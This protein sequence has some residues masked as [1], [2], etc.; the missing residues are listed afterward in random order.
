[1]SAQSPGPVIGVI[2]PGLGADDA[3]VA[4][5]EEVGG[6]LAQRGCPVVNGGLDGV[7]AAVSRGAASHGGLVIGILPGEDRSAGHNHL[8]FALPTG[9]GEMRNA[10]V[11]RASDAV[12]CIGGSWGTWSEVALAVRTGVPIIQLGGWQAPEP[13]PQMAGSPGE[14]VEV[15]MTLAQERIQSSGIMTD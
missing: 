14:A 11:V 9:L 10:L 8:T 3:V 15:A 2:G 12:I 5:A 7:M 6:L 1:M 13:G 4:W